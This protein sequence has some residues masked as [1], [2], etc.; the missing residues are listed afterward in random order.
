MVKK[1][2]VQG[3]IAIDTVVYLPSFP[4]P[5]SFMNSTSTVERTGGT[6]ANVAL[7]LCTADV[8]TGFIGYL[9]NDENGKKLLSVL[10]ESKIR[11]LIIT[12]IDGPTSHALILVDDRSER[13][14]ISLTQP[15]LRS[16]RMTNVP[17]QNE[18]VVAIILWREE[19]LADLQRA[20]SI[21]CF[22]VVGA[23]ALNDPKVDHANLL[24]GSYDDFP[25]SINPKDHLTR[26]DQIVLTDGT[27]GSFSFSSEEDLFQPAYVVK[28]LDTT[29][30]GD[31]F[32]A[33]FLTGIAHGLDTAKTLELASQWAASSVQVN[34]SV[35]PAFEVVKEQW[36]IQLI[37]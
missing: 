33:G 31:S 36:G 27:N 32:I 10:N 23:G 22:T 29:G 11:D 4:Q 25:K 28:T 12:H 9:G 7:G 16:L 13:T 17:F 24:I 15:H 18:E 19:F 8:E 35:P 5:G 26:F 34:S 37:L 1:V 6:S 30:A 14:I 20:N 21:G 2:W 3:P